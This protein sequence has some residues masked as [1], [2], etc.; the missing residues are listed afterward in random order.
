[1]VA[2][3]AVKPF[4]LLIC[5]VERSETSQIRFFAALRMTEPKALYGQS[6]TL[7]ITMR[8]DDNE[9]KGLLIPDTQFCFLG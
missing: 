9:A 4:H 2:L 5:H 3:G 7:R 6:H 8:Q 1:M